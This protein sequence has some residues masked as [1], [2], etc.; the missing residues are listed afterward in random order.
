[1]LPGQ[2]EC[3]GTGSRGSALSA[4][5]RKQEQAPPREPSV[6]VRVLR[7]AGDVVLCTGTVALLK[8][9]VHLLPAVE[10]DPLLRAGVLSATPHSEAEA[11]T[12]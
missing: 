5:P 9:T 6:L 1:M 12:L 3:T 4:H 8:G 2:P 7:D 11:R 10:A